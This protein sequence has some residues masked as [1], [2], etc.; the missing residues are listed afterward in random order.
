MFRM[1]MDKF[2]IQ[3]WNIL[4]PPAGP[5]AQRRVCMLEAKPHVQLQAFRIA[6]ELSHNLLTRQDV[7]TP[8]EKWRGNDAVLMD[9][10][11]KRVI[12]H[13]I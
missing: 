4:K 11:R 2:K 10:A 3:Y 6:A 1:E 5:N 8:R 9:S 13:H 7:E 12:L